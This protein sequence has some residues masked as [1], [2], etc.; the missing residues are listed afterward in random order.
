VTFPYSRILSR[1]WTFFPVFQLNTPFATA[2]PL[3]SPSLQLEISRLQPCKNSL[4]IISLLNLLQLLP[5]LLSIPRKNILRSIRI[6]LIYIRVIQT[7][8]LCFSYCAIDD[9][10]SRGVHRE[11]IAFEGPLE[12]YGEYWDKNG[13]VKLG[14]RNGRGE[15]LQIK[16]PSKS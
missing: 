11:V 6:I 15:V 9:V 8:F 2:S 12:G 16:G 1:A 5:I 10:T 3:P 14:K 7:H 4:G 13:L